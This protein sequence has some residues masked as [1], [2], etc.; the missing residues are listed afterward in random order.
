MLTKRGHILSLEAR[1]HQHH[2][3]CV[4]SLCSLSA[5]SPRRRYQHPY[6]QRQRHLVIGIACTLSSAGAPFVVF[7]NPSLLAFALPW[8][9]LLTASVS[10]RRLPF[11]PPHRQSLPSFLFCSTAFSANG[12][13]RSF[14]SVNKDLLQNI[15]A[16]LPARWFTSAACVSKLWSSVCNRILTRPKFSYALSLNPS[17]SIVFNFSGYTETLDW[18][19]DIVVPEDDLGLYAIDILDPSLLQEP[20]CLV[21]VMPSGKAIALPLPLRRTG[22]NFN[23]VIL[24]GK[25]GILSSFEYLYSPLALFGKKKAAP[26]PPSKKAAT[27]ITPANDE[28]A[29]WYDFHDTW[30][31][32]DARVKDTFDLKKTI[33]EL[34]QTLLGIILRGGY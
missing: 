22:S 3:R 6:R 13:G 12:N 21:M 2:P 34:H 27:A 19:S 4:V 16:R 15:L 33:Q 30:A 29:K 1:R 23:V 18:K 8:R 5:L 25:I 11:L 10:Q 20:Y 9:S 32:L 7:P 17:L 14:D 26:P 24:K 31:I 28:L